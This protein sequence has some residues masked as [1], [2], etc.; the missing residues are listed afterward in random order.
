MG[1]GIKKEVSKL[2][3]KNLA[4]NL[5]QNTANTG[6]QTQKAKKL[7]IEQKK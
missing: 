3:L 4:E 1:W 5:K 6:Y 7:N 2:I